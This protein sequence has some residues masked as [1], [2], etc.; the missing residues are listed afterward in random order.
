[1]GPPSRWLPGVSSQTLRS[2][3]SVISA[4]EAQQPAAREVTVHPSTM[5][6]VGVGRAAT[7]LR[8]LHLW[9]VR[10]V[11][12]LTHAHHTCAQTDTLTH[13]HVPTTC[14]HS[15]MLAHVCVHTLTHIYV[16]TTQAHSPHSH[17][18]MCPR[19]TG[20][21]THIHVQAN[22]LTLTCSHMS[23]CPPHTRT[24]TDMLTHVHVP[25]HACILTHAH[26]PT[27][28]THRHAH[29]HTDTLTGSP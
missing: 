9:D 16:P 27:T 26:V 18:Y 15:D 12:T 14:A 3:A 2:P 5:P 19:H 6:P 1:M 29:T 7:P 13:V 24:L 28:Q 11:V 22:T 8:P 4:P 25:T 20:T 21:L 10:P 17:T 23:T